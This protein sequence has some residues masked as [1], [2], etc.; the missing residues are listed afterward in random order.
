[1]RRLGTLGSSTLTGTAYGADKTGGYV[2][3]ITRAPSNAGT[4]WTATRR[5]RL[6]ISTNAAANA[7]AVTFTRIDTA[8][9]PE[10]FISGIALDNANPN[11]AWVSFVGYNA[12][13]PTTP[14]HVFEVTFDSVT[15]TATWTDISHN[16]ADLPITGIAR[17]AVTGNIY[18]AT[19]WGVLELIN[20]SSTW[21]LSA[22]NLPMVAV[23]GL[24]INSDARL[25]YAA[26][27]GRGIYR[28]DLSKQ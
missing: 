6:F 7:A 17:D 16:L 28:L 26:T 18:A 10:R 27:H 11:H 22:P 19:D 12:Y 13:T 4:L 5:G 20:G 15:A 23:Y 9:Q 14:G 21:T 8:S 2:V 24:T 1:M 25:L 3:A